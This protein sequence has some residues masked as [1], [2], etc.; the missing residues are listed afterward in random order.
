MRKYLIIAALFMLAISCGKKP[1]TGGEK[2]ETLIPEPPAEIVEANVFKMDFFTDLSNGQSFFANKDN[3]LASGHIKE[4]TGK[5]PL[6]YMFDRSDFLVGT[7]NSSVTIAKAC[8]YSPLFAQSGNIPTTVP[9]L[10]KGTG[11][12]TAYSIADFD[13]ATQDG[14]Y[15]SGL[16]LTAP[17]KTP[18]KIG[19][20]T[21]SIDDVN[22]FAKVAVLKN[23]ELHEESVLVGT[24]DNSVK[25]EFIAW[26]KKDFASVR[27]AFAE[28]SDTARDLY[29]MVPVSYAIREISQ[30]RKVNLG[31]FRISIEKLFTI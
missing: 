18:C 30:E 5:K 8:G 6:V 7:I 22:A 23:Y 13:G 14:A 29:V 9:K 11:I 19:I 4:Q 27:L 24:I 15:I 16:Q 20:Y 21:A 17:L 10:V 26:V 1:V 31:Y 25:E 12:V 3:S 2:P 28:S